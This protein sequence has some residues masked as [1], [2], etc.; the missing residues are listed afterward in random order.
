MTTLRDRILN[1]GGKPDMASIATWIGHSAPRF[2]QLM[3]CFLHDEYRVVQRA[4]WIISLVADEQP[5]LLQPHLP[6]MVAR[7]QEAGLPVAVKRN[8]VRV[9][10][11]LHI[12]ED[13]QGA[14]M[15]QC[16]IFLADP[17]E[18][19]AVRA[20]SMTVLANLAKEYP[21]IKGEIVMLIEDALE[22]EPTPG[23]VSRAKKVLK[24]LNN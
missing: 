20:F 14:V 7:M 10:Q 23:I 5:S 11:V 16:F 13:L 9:L 24:L 1:A 6:A 22:Q 21:E 15:E 2:A 12:P 18:T 8:V 4:A 19:V 17:Q 3:E